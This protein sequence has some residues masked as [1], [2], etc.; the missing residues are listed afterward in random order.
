MGEGIVSGRWGNPDTLTHLVH[1]ESLRT[2]CGIKAF[3][4]PRPFYLRTFSSSLTH[5][6]CFRCIDSKVAKEIRT[7]ISATMAEVYG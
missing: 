3:P 4:A 7:K 1:L 6:T 2:I 5:L